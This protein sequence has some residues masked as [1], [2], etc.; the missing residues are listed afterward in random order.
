MV[1]WC[2]RDRREPRA[3][4]AGRNR[5][6]ATESSRG[7]RPPRRASPAHGPGRGNLAHQRDATARRNCRAPARRARRPDGGRPSGGR[8][9]RDDRAPTG[10]RRWRRE[11]RP[12]RSG[13][14]VATSAST[15][16]TDGSRFRAAVSM[17]GELSMPTTSASGKRSTRSSVEL[18]G[19]Q[20][21][22]TTRAAS[23]SGT[24]ASRSR[25]GRVRSSS[26]LRY[27]LGDQVMLALVHCLRRDASPALSRDLSIRK[28]PTVHPRES[29]DRVT[30]ADVT[31]LRRLRQLTLIPLL[32]TS[33]LQ[34]RG[35][36]CTVIVYWVPAFAGM[37]VGGLHWRLAS[38]HA[39]SFPR[40]CRPGLCSR[41]SSSP[42]SRDTRGG[43][44]SLNASR[45]VRIRALVEAPA[46][47]TFGSRARHITLSRLRVA[48]QREGFSLQEAAGRSAGGPHPGLPT[49]RLR[50]VP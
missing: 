4:S 20:P 41:L 48:E 19:P 44:R 39:F 21:I 31:I 38:R 5:H 3:A 24:A 47:A 27:W 29:G 36:F 1:E 26:N 28:A 46:A 6:S 13:I 25:A 7:R 22:S 17:S 42:P 10:T 9:P 34:R 40:P 33:L 15:K 49:V 50:A 30:T 12:D 23:G 43:G 8:A 14:Q 35:S 16:A 45:V 32:L 2:A 37:T 18:P 11:G